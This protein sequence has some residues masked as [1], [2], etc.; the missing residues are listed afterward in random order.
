MN[1]KIKNI[2]YE[3]VKEIKLNIKGI[4]LKNEDIF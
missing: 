4:K 1:I 2:F 3:L